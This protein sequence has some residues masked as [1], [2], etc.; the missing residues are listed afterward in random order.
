MSSLL[1]TTTTSRLSSVVILV[2]ISEL[3]YPYFLNIPVT[4]PV[5]LLLLS[6]TPFLGAVLL[7]HQVVTPNLSPIACVF[8]AILSTVGLEPSTFSL[9]VKRS[10]T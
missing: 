5:M 4:S 7:F 3:L 10:T 8:L 2:Y 1:L 6:G 9:K